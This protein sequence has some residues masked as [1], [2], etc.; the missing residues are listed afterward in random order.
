VTGGSLPISLVVGPGDEHDS[1]RFREVMEGMRVKYGRG[2]PRSRPGEVAGDS[3]YDTRDVRAYL[4]RR[5]IKANIPV[6]I[7]NRRRPRHGRTYRLDLEAYKRMRSSVERFFAWLTNGFR[8]LAIRWER[9]ASTFTGFIQL[10]C[11]IIYL[12]VFR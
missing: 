11:I 9:L 10:A 4:R 3:A 8:R 1:K 2:R 7:R 6:N 12:R 5:G